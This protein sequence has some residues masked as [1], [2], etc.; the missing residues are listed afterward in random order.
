MLLS[1]LCMP[2]CNVLAFL[3]RRLKQ[4]KF[5]LLGSNLVPVPLKFDLSNTMSFLCSPH[6]LMQAMLQESIFVR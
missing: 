3:L 2:A 1:V 4:D 6:F 5:S